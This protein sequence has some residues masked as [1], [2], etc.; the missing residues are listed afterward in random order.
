M[1]S[2][3]IANEMEQFR[4]SGS[5]QGSLSGAEEQVLVGFCIIDHDIDADVLIY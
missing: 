1:R 4:S 5:M 3:Q 2:S